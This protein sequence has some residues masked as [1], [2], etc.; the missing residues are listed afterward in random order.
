LVKDHHLW[1]NT[2]ATANLAGGLEPKKHKNVI[3]QRLK[4]P[5]KERSDKGQSRDNYQGVERKIPNNTGKKYNTKPIEP[6]G[7]QDKEPRFIAAFWRLHSMDET[8]T[9]SAA[10]LE[11]KLNVFFEDYEARQI[12][13]HGHRWWYP[14]NLKGRVVDL[15]YNK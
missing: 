8:L 13:A 3:L 7:K 4:M 1:I 11:E 10:E 12:K 15:R 6:R 14:E 9:W 2:I 5:R